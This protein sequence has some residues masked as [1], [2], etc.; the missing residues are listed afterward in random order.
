MSGRYGEPWRAG[1]SY[2]S[3]IVDGE[4]PPVCPRCFA[5]DCPNHTD[6]ERDRIVYGGGLV[7]ESVF[8]EDKRR[9]LIAAV[10]ACAG[11]PTE[12]LES[13][14]IARMRELVTALV[15]GVPDGPAREVARAIHAALGRAPTP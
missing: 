9:R 15:N 8:D 6:A 12:A 13:G 10:N 2:A 7:A 14:V 1:R 3:V 5:Y 4:E 11:L